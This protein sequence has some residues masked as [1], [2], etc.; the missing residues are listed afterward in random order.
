MTIN[1]IIV[2]VY[3]VGFYLEIGFGNFYGCL[4]KTMV[5]GEDQTYKNNVNNCFSHFSKLLAINLKYFDKV[6][7]SNC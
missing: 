5:T 3:R 6:K 2:Y 1:D 4:R 7:V